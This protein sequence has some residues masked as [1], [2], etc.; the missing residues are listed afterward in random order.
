MLESRNLAIGR[1][2]FLEFSDHSGAPYL[3]EDF[4]VQ[5]WCLVF[6]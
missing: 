5:P 1:K 6:H 4:K 2:R 3:T